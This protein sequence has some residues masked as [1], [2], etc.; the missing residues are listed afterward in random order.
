MKVAVLFVKNIFASLG[1]T[2]AASATDAGIQ[3]KMHGTGTKTL[4]ISNEEVNDIMKIVETL[5]DSD[6]LLKK[7]TKTIE[8]ETKTK[9]IIFRIVIRS[10][11]S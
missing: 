9:K 11:R 7:I 10:F 4:I 2:A 1:I 5:E 8:N 3:K 6:I